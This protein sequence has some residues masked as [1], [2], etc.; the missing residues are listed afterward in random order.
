MNINV[1]I[2]R[3]VLVGIPVTSRQR[4]ALH[5]AVEREL[6]RLLSAGR[7][8]PELLP[9]GTVPSVRA[10]SIELEDES[11]PLHL[12]HQIARAVYR[13]IGDGPKSAGHDRSQRR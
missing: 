9:G 6:V 4:E 11:S 8:S 12:G 2:E 10:N 5:A 1:H 3:L 13:G 7:L